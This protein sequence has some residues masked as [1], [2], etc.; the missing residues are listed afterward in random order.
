[1]APDLPGYGDS[2]PAETGHD[3]LTYSTAIIESLLATY[4]T[5]PVK[6]VLIGHDRGARVIHRL[7]V[8]KSHYPKISILGV[9]LADIIPTFEQFAA[10][11]N[12]ATVTRYFHWGFLPNVALSV[13]MI[14]AFGPGRFCRMVIQAGA[15]KNAQ[16]AKSLFDND[17][18]DVYAASFEKEGVLEATSRDY[19]AAAKE[20]YVAQVEDQK[21]GRKIDVP[22]L[23]LYSTQNLGAMADVPSI[24]KNWVKDGTD[25]EVK[26]MSD[27]YG[28]FFLEEAPHIS[29][30]H[31]VKFIKGVEG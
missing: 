2:T 20:D 18:V 14:K 21:A 31:I 27:G 26:G 29:Y 5:F 12:P 22:T 3:K 25:L 28:H 24:W 23:V 6:V 10:F 15:G 1:M 9:V 7:A 4:T 17:S 30:D 19:E 16:G 13:P 11:S 8:S